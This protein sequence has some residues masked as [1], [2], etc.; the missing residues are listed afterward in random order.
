[1]KIKEIRVRTTFIEECL[2]SSPA[3]TEIYRDYI[4]SKS[5]DA[6][7][8]EDEIAAVGVDKVAEKVMTIFPKMPSSD[9]KSFIPFAYDYQWRGF[10]KEILGI[11]KKVPG[12]KAKCISAHKKFVD[13]YLFIKER[14]I[15]IDM[16]GL[17]MDVN[18]RSL[19]AS[20]PTGEHT[21][22]AISESVPEGS[23]M[24]F[25]IM[26]TIDDDTDDKKKGKSKGDYEAAIIECLD[27]G[28]LKGFGQ[29]RN[30]GKGRFTYELI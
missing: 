26:L 1:M 9:G 3:N 2:G 21:A 13:N 18:Q 11:L 17:K 6:G 20:T 14:Q 19:R 27:Y 12:S 28:V 24:E 22:L 4:A 5:P 29:W 25:T 15:P 10:F 16:H 30:S 23:T 8:I 7:T